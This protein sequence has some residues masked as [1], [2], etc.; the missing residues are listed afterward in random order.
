MVLCVAGQRSIYIYIYIYIFIR[1]VNKA[2]AARIVFNLANRLL[3][4]QIGFRK[5]LVFR[6]KVVNIRLCYKWAAA[7]KAEKEPVLLPPI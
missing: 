5:Q 6:M 7:Y 4:L 1:F 3:A 2:W